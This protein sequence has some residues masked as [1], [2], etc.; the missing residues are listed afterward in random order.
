MKRPVAFVI[1]HEP[2]ATRT[3]KNKTISIIALTLTRALGRADVDVVRIHPNRLDHSLSS[4]YCRAVHVCPNLYDSEDALNKYLIGLRSQYQRKVVLIP[5]SDDCSI[6]IAKNAQHLSEHFILLN[7]TA[8]TMERVKDKRRQYDLA[9]A[10]GV[11][12]PET[13]FP[14]CENELIDVATQLKHY[15]YIIKPVEAQ[16]W[17][18]KKYSGISDGKKAVVVHD[19]TE[20][21]AEYRRISVYDTNIMVQE[22]ING[23]DELLYTFLAYCSATEKPLAY[24]VRSKLRQYPIDF[25]YC[26]ASISCHNKEVE[27]YARRLLEQSSYVGMVGVEFKYDSI[28][29]EYKLIEINTR[30]VNTI[31]LSIAC[32]VN[33]PLIAYL[34]AI[35]ENPNPVTQWR[36]GVVW[37]WFSQ[38]LSAARELKRLGRLSTF[39]WLRSYLVG[40]RTHAIFSL[41]DVVP[42]LQFYKPYAKRMLSK[43]VRK[44]LLRG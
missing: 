15:P 18:L 6:Y 2:D 27:A 25:G 39:Q 5:A 37:L 23:K 42:F 7:P 12:I 3:E 26:T 20:L 22:I 10:A 31:G 44:G 19:G 28:A 4:R 21:L 33:L 30:P 34:D 17:R 1:S 43:I 16:K 41:Y 13:Y 36:D 11:S 35:G 29:D 32:G 8:K 40:R 38:D 24:C 9:S 14:Q